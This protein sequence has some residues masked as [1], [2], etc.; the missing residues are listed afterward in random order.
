MSSGTK[1][2]SNIVDQAS[3]V[4]TR[5]TVHCHRE[6]R[7]FPSQG[8]DASD[9]HLASATFSQFL[10]R[11]TILSFFLHLSR[12]VTESLPLDFFSLKTTEEPVLFFLEIAARLLRNQL[13]ECD[14]NL[15]YL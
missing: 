1:P 7:R 9:C 13:L 4:G 5:R 10:E 12:K 15:Q 8:S 2:D 14:H 6:V 11:G 3:H